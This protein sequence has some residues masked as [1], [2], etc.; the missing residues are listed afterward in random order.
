[1]Q[2][3]HGDA[4][5]VQDAGDAEPMGTLRVVELITTEGHDDHRAS[6]RDGP[7]HGPQAAM[8]DHYVGDREGIGLRYVLLDRYTR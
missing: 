3:F 8:A 6:L 7:K 1:L 4:L 5:W 2:G